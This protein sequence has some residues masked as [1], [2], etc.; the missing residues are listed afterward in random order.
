[1]PTCPKCNADHPEGTEF[2][3]D[4][5]A[6]LTGADESL[7]VA[8]TAYGPAAVRDTA[9]ESTPQPFVRSSRPSAD[10]LIGKVF[11]GVY[12]VVDRLGVGGM[13]V[14]Y[15]VEH[16]N[17][18]KEFALKVLGQVAADHPD[19]VERF[20][21]EAVSASH[22][23][24]D[25][26]VDIITLD[27][28]P[29][30]NLYI[31]MELLRGESLADAIHRDAPFAVERAL[32]IFYQICHALHAAHSA[33]IIHRDMKPENVFLTKKSDAEFVKIL[34]FGI[35]K[36]HAAEHERVRITK[37]GHV[38]GTPLYMSPEQ[39]K[40]E[41]GL[42]QRV[43][44]YSLGVMLFEMLQGEPPFSGDNYFQ[45]IWKH[46]NEAPPE[47][48]ADVPQG[49]REAVRQA[50][51]KRP[52]ERYDTMLDF[53]EAVLAAVPAVQPPAFLLDF[54]PS[55]YTSL[56][57]RPAPR[58]RLERRR[59][60]WILL[61]ALCVVGLVAATALA[62]RAPPAN[63]AGAAVLLE[64]ASLVDAAGGGHTATGDAG[65]AADSNTAPDTNVAPATPARVRLRVASVPEGATVTLDGVEV[66]RT[67]LDIERDRGDGS[68]VALRLEKRGFEAEARAISLDQDVEI[69]VSLR[70]RSTAGG[71]GPADP[72][73]A[74]GPIKTVF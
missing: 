5:G 27:A 67:P 9:A 41:S 3:P 2:C 43:D 15:R 69:A 26:I 60:K 29:D 50:L 1:M 17:L 31:V 57:P 38:L 46:A 63:D 53:E 65:A 55:G 6:P 59:A 18:K 21:Q 72:G 11:G 62:P 42:D 58:R 61:G 25:N 4:D 52:D 44:I 24:H 39:A 71:G 66:G 16:V 48:T 47:V 32:P 13:G 68:G 74:G 8:A 22:I 19:A 14:V 56:A 7:G 23:E 51:S 30:G 35:S 45:L 70:R 54:R 37:T 49:L 36:I 10:E 40:G 33:G 64:T 20:R 12:R 34:D 73:G 28:T